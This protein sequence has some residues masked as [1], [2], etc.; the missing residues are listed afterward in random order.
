MK[1]RYG[2]RKR[3]KRRN[4]VLLYYNSSLGC[5]FLGS[6]AHHCDMRTERTTYYLVE[7]VAHVNDSGMHDTI[8]TRPIVNNNT[9]ARLLGIVLL[10][11][12]LNIT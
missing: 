1:Q 3:R 7:H 9:H 11:Q 5:A 10:A 12:C 2:E 8:N 4:K 6:N